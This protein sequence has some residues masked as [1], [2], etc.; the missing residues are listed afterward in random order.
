M[1]VVIDE[2]GSVTFYGKNYYVVREL[3]NSTQMTLGFKNFEE[4]ILLIEE[5]SYEDALFLDNDNAIRTKKTYLLDNVGY[6]KKVKQL[7]KF[8]LDKR[9]YVY[10]GGY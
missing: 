7:S 9:E 6:Y 2:K 3:L 10:Q 8:C 5:I 1:I 4:D